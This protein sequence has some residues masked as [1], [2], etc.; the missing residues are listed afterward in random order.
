MASNSQEK[1]GADSFWEDGTAAAMA[2]HIAYELKHGQTRLE[3]S[4]QL[5]A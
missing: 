1:V 2:T 4:H 5:A 3:Q